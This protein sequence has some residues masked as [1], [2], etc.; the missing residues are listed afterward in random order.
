ML[1]SLKRKFAYLYLQATFVYVYTIAFIY[2]LIF[3]RAASKRKKPI[4]KIAAVWYN[5]PDLNGSN[6]RF[7]HWQKYFEEAGY[8]YDNFHISSIRET[9]EMFNN[10]P[11]AEKY[12]F[13]RINL[14]RR[15]KQFYRLK[16]YDTVWI[17]RAFVVAYPL[18]QA[19]LER[20]IKRMVGYVVVDS[21]D[22]QD[23]ESNPELVLDTMAQADRITVAFSSLKEFF[24]EHFDD[25]VQFNWTI[26]VDDYIVKPDYKLKELPIIG[27]MGNRGNFYHVQMIENH[28]QEVAKVKPFKFMYICRDKQDINIPDATV[29]HRLFGDDYFK[30]IADFDIG[31]S[32]VFGDT[33]THKGKIAMK[34][35]EFLMSAVPQVCS[36]VAISEFVEDR[37]D[38]LIAE[39][40]ED[41]SKLLLELMND[42]YLREKLGKNGREVFMKHYTYESEF[43]KV[44]AAL[45]KFD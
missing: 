32:P 26:P 24:A 41:W 16:D 43:P 28:L 17:H 5:P 45:T 37:K 4:K 29:E 19:F 13:Y 15:L 12:K 40:I 38:V 33:I 22:G 42:K 34:H 10:A 7:G 20:C 3:N 11:W 18:K 21:T 39:Q 30:L 35:Q 31:I 23:Y 25:I 1:E 14:L 2:S 9:D 36:P 27:W 8:Q 6:L 44:L